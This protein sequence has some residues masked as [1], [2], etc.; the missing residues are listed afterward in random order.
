MGHRR[1]HEL[2]HIDAEPM[3]T[4]ER[5]NGNKPA[6]Q[7]EGNDRQ[8]G[9]VIGIGFTHALRKAWLWKI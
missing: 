7:A 2:Q 1:S 9:S 3:T 5:N 6:M 4:D 8:F